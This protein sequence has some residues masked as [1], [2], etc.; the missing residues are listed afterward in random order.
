MCCWTRD[1]NVF[2]V[3]AAAFKNS[4]KLL[5]FNIFDEFILLTLAVHPWMGLGLL[6]HLPPFL[7]K[8]RPALP[9]WGFMTIL[10]LRHEVVSPTLNPSKVDHGIPFSWGR[11][12]WPV[13]CGRSYQELRCH[14]LSS[15]DHLTLHQ[16]QHYDKGEIPS[17]AVDE[18][19]F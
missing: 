14:R 3:K 11:H 19:S 6:N 12:L 2:R 1:F 7:F 8:N 9:L 15:T 5:I 4:L 17:V 18:F 10:F 16:L 13:R